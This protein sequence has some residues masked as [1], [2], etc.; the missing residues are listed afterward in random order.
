MQHLFKW[1]PICPHT[2]NLFFHSSNLENRWEFSNC[3][4]APAG[5]SMQATM[6]G[7]WVWKKHTGGK[8]REKS[9]REQEREREIKTER[10]C[11]W[12]QLPGQRPSIVFQHTSPQL[13]QIAI[14]KWP[15]MQLLA[16]AEPKWPSIIKRQPSRGLQFRRYSR[17]VVV[18]FRVHCRGYQTVAPRRLEWDLW[19]G[20]LQ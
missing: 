12:I 18:C 13:S 20:V 17:A 2:E 9:T 6:K 5:S 19:K 1:W 10:K 14:E 8:K 15:V 7:T 11:V 4:M 3:Y 16:N